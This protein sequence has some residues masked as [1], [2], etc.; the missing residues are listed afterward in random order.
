MDKE[1]DKLDDPKPSH[2]TNTI[3]GITSDLLHI[4]IN[5]PLLDPY[6]CASLVQEVERLERLPPADDDQSKKLAE[7][8]VGSY[9]KREVNDPVIYARAVTSIFSEFPVEVAKEAINR[10]TRTLKFLPTR[11]DVF[12]ACSNTLAQSKIAASV[13]RVHLTEHARRQ[14]IETQEAERK[15]DA[16]NPEPEGQVAGEKDGKD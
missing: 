5:G 12:E 15:A 1:L 8:L 10:I 14:A 9:P 11:A 13:G 7:I 2:I 6:V 3:R 16:E 4:T